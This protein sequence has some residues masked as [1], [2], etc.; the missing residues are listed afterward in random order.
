MTKRRSLLLAASLVL[1]AAP[2][3][4]AGRPIL[5]ELFTSEGCSSCPPADAFLTELAARPEVL[6]LSMHVDYWDRLGW[7]DRFSSAALTARQ[8]RYAT[9]LGLATVYTPQMVIDGHWQAVG[10]DRAA[11]GEALAAASRKRA[12][13]PVALGFSGNKAR[14]RIAAAPSGQPTISA[15]V[16]LVG[17]DRG[18]SDAVHGGENSGRT[19]NYVDVVRGIARIG[20]FHGKATELSATMP[21]HAERV[22][23][24]VQGGDGRVLGIGVA[25]ANAP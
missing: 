8:R 19:L 12:A 15:S 4:A 3:S 21:W 5:I 16:I 18:A 10:S 2:A 1:A 25:D 17:F 9:L 6:A 13:V 11:V 20:A 24:I 7:K 14:V 23:A 22:A